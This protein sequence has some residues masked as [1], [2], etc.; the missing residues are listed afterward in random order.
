M[1]KDIADALFVIRLS[2]VILVGAAALFGGAVLVWMNTAWFLKI[3]AALVTVPLVFLA[4]LFA[5]VIGESFQASVAAPRRPVMKQEH[6]IVEE[7]T[8]ATTRSDVESQALR[9]EFE[10]KQR[11][12]HAAAERRML[13]EGGK[14]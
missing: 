8:P 13:Q 2:L 11:Q 6:A 14:A 7:T 9:E 4:G 5:A 10:L 12:A 3:L 1:R